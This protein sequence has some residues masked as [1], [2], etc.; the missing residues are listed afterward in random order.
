MDTNAREMDYTR[1][2]TIKSQCYIDAIDLSDGNYTNEPIYSKYTNNN[3]NHHHHHH[4]SDDDHHH[5]LT[6]TRDQADGD[7]DDD[8]DED[9]IACG[10]SVV[11]DTKLEKDTKL[12]LNFSVDRILGHESIAR[13]TMENCHGCNSA[14]GLNGNVQSQHNQSP[15]HQQHQQQQQ[16]LFSMPFAMATMLSLNNAIVRPMPVRYLANRSPTGN[17][18]A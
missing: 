5:D 17:P 8:D 13:K 10:Q 11:V 3:N 1:L 15:H 4:H 9:N 6:T 16:P 2:K 14:D 12:K 18:G 7:D